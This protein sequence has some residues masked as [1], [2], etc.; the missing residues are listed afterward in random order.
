MDFAVLLKVG[1]SFIV[2]SQVTSKYKPWECAMLEK[3]SQQIYHTSIH[4]LC[5]RFLPSCFGQKPP[6]FWQIFPAFHFHVKL[7]HSLFNQYFLHDSLPFFWGF[8]AIFIQASTI[9]CNNFGHANAL[10]CL[11]FVQGLHSFMISKCR[12]WHLRGTYLKI[13]RRGVC[14][15]IPLRAR[16]FSTCGRGYTTPTT[17]LC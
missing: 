9:A 5:Q 10:D 12:K 16:A 7:F 15:R 4:S 2:W 3:N 8:S 14:H 6:I 17:S 1:Y 11:D 13:I